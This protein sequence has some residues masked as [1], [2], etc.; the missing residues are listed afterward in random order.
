MYKV[1]AAA[2]A[3]L[4]SGVIGSMTLPVSD[5]QSRLVPQ[6]APMPGP[7]PPMVVE[8]EP[9]EDTIVMFEGPDLRGQFARPGQPGTWQIATS[10]DMTI[11][12]N[13]ATGECYHLVGREGNFHWKPI[14]RPAPRPETQWPGLREL[15]TFPPMP[16][17]ERP[18]AD[19]M[20][21][22]LEEARR[23]LKDAEGK[24]R[25][26]LKR[27]IE[28]LERALEKQPAPENQPKRA[29]DRVE[30]LET[31]LTRLNDKVAALEK[32]IKET[33]SKKESRELESMASELRAEIKRVKQELEAA[34]KG[35]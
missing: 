1:I 12:L 9:E 16:P 17:A 26:A 31:L 14:E 21:K 18:G 25:E 30:E 19:R 20:R 7:M 34:R 35:R 22:A 32:R 10:R 33:D 11:L 6:P 3:V 5:A 8:L 2:A 27:K 24:E 15:P 4:L 23:D 13:T 29:L 28:E